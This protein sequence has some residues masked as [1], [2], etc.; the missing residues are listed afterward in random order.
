MMRVYQQN[1]L[2]H[3]TCM[4]S[5]MERN[6]S[7]VLPSLQYTPFVLY[8]L[9]MLLLK[10]SLNAIISILSPGFIKRRC[11]EINYLR[12]RFYKFQGVSIKKKKNIFVHVRLCVCH[13][14][15]HNKHKKKYS[16]HIFL[17]FVISSLQQLLLQQLLE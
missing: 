4:L 13:T 3:T 16:T 12:K 7:A 2:Y 15:D 10:G 1:K 11:I 17:E 6:E 5:I 9:K 8:F 14:R